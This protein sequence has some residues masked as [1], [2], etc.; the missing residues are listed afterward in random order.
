MRKDSLEETEFK[1][2]WHSF[3]SEPKSAWEIQLARDKIVI[4]S[5]AI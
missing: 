2:Y 5:E 3:T 1:V 4:P